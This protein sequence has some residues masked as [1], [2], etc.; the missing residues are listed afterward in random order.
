MSHGQR[1]RELSSHTKKHAFI[2]HD[3]ASRNHFGFNVQCQKASTQIRER[4]VRRV[5]FGWIYL[6][7]HLRR[8]PVGLCTGLAVLN[9]IEQGDLMMNAARMGDALTTRLQS[10]MRMAMT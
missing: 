4:F 5:E 6:W 10:L 9:E 3:K 7:L 1:M 8:Q 2:T